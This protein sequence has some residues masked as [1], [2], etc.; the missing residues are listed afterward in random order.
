MG[1][2][3]PMR[4]IGP[5]SPPPQGRGE[6]GTSGRQETRPMPRRLPHLTLLP[7]LGLLVSLGALLY[8]Q[9]SNALADKDKDKDKAASGGSS[10]DVDKV[11]R[12]IAARHEYQK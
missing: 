6:E 2:V 3:G 10:T 11:E 4:P 8:A 9:T 12:L 1:L 7:A 5:I